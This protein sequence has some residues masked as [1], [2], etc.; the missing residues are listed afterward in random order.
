MALLWLSRSLHFTIELSNKLSIEVSR[1]Q[2]VIVE[3]MGLEEELV[4]DEHLLLDR[5]GDWC[6]GR[7]WDGDGI[8]IWMGSGW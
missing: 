1:V 5:R 4:G 8:G 2:A 7:N 3:E 6:Y